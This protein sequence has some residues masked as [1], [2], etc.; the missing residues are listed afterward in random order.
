MIA[1][2]Y[3]GTSLGRIHLRK[4]EPVKLEIS[5]ERRPGNDPQAQLIW[6]RVNDLP[7]PQPLALPGKPT[8][9]SRSWE[10]PARWKARRCRS[11]KQDS[12]A[13]IGPA[14]TC[15]RRKKRCV[16]AVASAGKPLVVVLMNGSALAAQWEKEH[17]NAILESWYSGEEGGAASRTR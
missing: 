3:G 10:S 11:A 5:Y 7:D 9:S 2:T 14:S 12:K 15:P 17:A 16:Q 4:G 1:Q 13:A 6:Q 8:S